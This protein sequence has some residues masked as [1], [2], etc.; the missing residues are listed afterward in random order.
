M[1]TYNVHFLDLSD[2]PDANWALSRWKKSRTALVR[3]IRRLDADILAFQEMQAHDGEMA[4]RD[5]RMKWLLDALPDYRAAA[6]EFGA[7]VAVGQPIFYRPRAFD[8]LD[9]GFAFYNDPDAPFQSVRAFAGYPDAVTWARFRHRASGRA[10][11]VFNVHLHFL[12]KAQRLRSARRV[13]ALARGAQVRGDAAFVIG[14]FNAR[15]NSRTLEVFREA[16][17]D[18][19]RQRG[20]TFHFNM[21]VH[22]YGAIDHMLHDDKALPVGPSLT[23]RYKPGEVWPSDHYP[24][25]T[26]FRLLR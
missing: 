13:L 9:E 23:L 22:L 6:D 10:L 17:F 26:D 12:D 20:A 3:V 25:R 21:G 1:A 18:L 8:L 15:R 2:A 16:G 11:T 24:V 19:T 14:D 7:D 4:R 5:T